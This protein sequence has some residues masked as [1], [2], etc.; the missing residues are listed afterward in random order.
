M[1]PV[2]LHQALSRPPAAFP[3]AIPCAAAAWCRHSERRSSNATR[4]LLCRRCGTA[5]FFVSAPGLNF[6]A[7]R[8][9]KWLLSAPSPLCRPHPGLCQCHVL[10]S[11]RGRRHAGWAAPPW[12][13]LPQE[14]LLEEVLRVL[15]GEASSNESWKKKGHI[16]F[17][18]H[19]ACLPLSLTFPCRRACPAASIASVRAAITPQ[20]I[21]DADRP[22]V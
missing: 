22:V 5:V 7:P 12:L 14:P 2:W 13:Q 11:D 4:M 16:S 9:E 1:V 3:T 21:R 19:S 18:S 17:V 15:S 10:H 6:N 20:A 8:T